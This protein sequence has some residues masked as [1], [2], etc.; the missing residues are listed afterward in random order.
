MTDVLMPSR[1]AASIADVV[2]AA[3]QRPVETGG[4]TLGAST[5]PLS[6]LA[7]TG[8]EG[9][10]RRRNL[11]RVSGGAMA[12]LF[13]WADSAGITIVAQWHSHGRLAFLSETD[14]EHGFNVPGFRT[15]VVPF[16]R[17]PT[18]DPAAWGWWMFNGRHW[19]ET[20]PP[21]LID[22]EFRVITFGEE[23]VVEH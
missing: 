9:V 6:V 23:G 17:S 13:E 18:P 10:E 15:T 16:Y 1:M 21:R 14:V 19:V 4:F 20:P 5:G 12:V 8:T 22:A 2:H 11:F 7:L 3:G